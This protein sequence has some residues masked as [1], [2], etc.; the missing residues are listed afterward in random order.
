[1]SAVHPCDL[2]AHSLLRRYADNGYADCYV[3]AIDIPVSHA[4][5][6][7]AFYTTALF[8]LERI[9]LRLAG[10]PSTDAQA[11]ELATGARD[12]FAAWRVEA[13]DTDQIL[14][15][16]SSGRTKSWLMVAR[17]LDDAAVPRTRLYF[18]SA[19]VPRLNVAS[20]RNEMGRVFRMLLG[21]HKMY[22]RALLGSARRRL[23]AGSRTNA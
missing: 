8:K 13:R 15:S 22:S 18:G 21:F 16:D 20:G 4:E 23:I 11:Q 9:I 7:A 10:L 2:P 17:T 6:V 3:T 12:A 19:V 5:F 14:L 1:M